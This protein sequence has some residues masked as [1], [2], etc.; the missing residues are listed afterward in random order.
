MKATQGSSLYSRKGPPVDLYGFTVDHVHSLHD[1][2]IA[3]MSVVG[4]KAAIPE[5]L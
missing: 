4:T 1:A 3:N 5:M 2:V